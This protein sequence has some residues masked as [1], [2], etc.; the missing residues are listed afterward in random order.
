MRAIEMDA[1]SKNTTTHISFFTE[2]I[3]SLYFKVTRINTSAANGLG[4]YILPTIKH[5][6]LYFTGPLNSFT[7]QCTEAGSL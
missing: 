2:T 7:V 6:L 5:Y 1:D 4:I 3:Y